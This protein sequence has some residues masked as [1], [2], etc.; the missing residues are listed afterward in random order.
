MNYIFLEMLSFGYPN[1]TKLFNKLSWKI[2]K[3]E[4]NILIGAN[5]SGK[6]TL[7]LLILG[8]LKPC[9]GMIYLQGKP[10]LDYSL[11]EI[12]R[13]IGYLFQNTSV[14]LF[15]ESVNEEINFS[16]L[17]N[18]DTPWKKHELLYFFNLEEIATSFPLK[19]SKGEQQRL[20]LASIC[21]LDPPFFLLDEP[22]AGLDPESTYKLGT[23]ILN[24]HSKGKGFLI[25][26]HDSSFV[27]L[28]QKF[29]IWH[30]NKMAIN[31]GRCISK[32]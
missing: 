32:D 17:Q 1:K 6:S 4:I 19:L 7:S 16:L 3:D 21:A 28:L 12:G 30:I 9:S 31:K 26:T 22:S 23:L 10:I 27:K 11:A 20:A 18:P 29:N 2:P 13:R 25:L 15:S 5:G 8:L 14:Q 24:L